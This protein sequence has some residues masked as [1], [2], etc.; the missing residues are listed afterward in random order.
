MHHD[1]K[2]EAIRLRREE[3]WSYDAIRKKLGVAKSTLHEWLKHFP[4]TKERILELRRANWK[5][6]EVKIELFR[7]AMQ[8]KREKRNREVYEKY[9]RLL[10]KFSKDG[11]FAGGLMLYLAEGN[12]TSQSQ[13]SLANT[14]SRV[15]RFFIKW[16]NHF[17]NV[18]R[19]TLRAQLHLYETMNVAE[20]YKFWKSELALDD[21]QFYKIQI[22]KLQKNSFSYQ[23]SFR[24][25]TCSLVFSGVEKKR[26]IMM[27]IKAFLD[28][29]LET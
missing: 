29:N 12:K 21:Y 23:E 26:E 14:D 20:E 7:L 16:L 8:E 11:F 13:V 19:H 17:F 9:R 4:L 6:N 1:L 22:R 2:Q 10:S 24:H 3:E 18:P 28:L 15:I 25:G 5:K 27:A